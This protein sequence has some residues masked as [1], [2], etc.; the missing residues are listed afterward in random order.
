MKAAVCFETHQPLRVVDV[1]LDP[2]RAGVKEGLETVAALARR[3]IAMISC[4]PVTFA[5][6][7]RGLLDLGFDLK[8]LEGFDMFPQTHHLEALAWLERGA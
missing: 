1:A 5:R 2:P 7:L 3:S 8:H 6:D 4:D